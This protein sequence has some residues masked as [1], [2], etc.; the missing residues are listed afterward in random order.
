M[1]NKV[2]KFLVSIYDLRPQSTPGVQHQ[3]LKKNLSDFAKW[4]PTW[5]YE[6]N[7]GGE[8]R[9]QVTVVI[10]HFNSQHFNTRK[11]ISYSIHLIPS[12]RVL[13]LLRDIRQL[14]P[15]EGRVDRFAEI[16]TFEWRFIALCLSCLEHSIGFCV[17]YLS[18]SL[19]TQCS[20]K[21]GTELNKSYLHSLA[22]I[23]L[24]RGA[25]I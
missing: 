17:G 6:W 8:T 7:Q 13:P 5:I 16:L 25:G 15:H 11:C 22:F 2:K 20:A 10:I 4:W 24:I 12:S 18:W 9:H 23:L 21:S 19:A 14:L 3:N 1:V